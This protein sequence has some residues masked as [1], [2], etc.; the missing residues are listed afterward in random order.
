MGPMSEPSEPAPPPG[1][2]Q[3]TTTEGPA[4][5][6]GAPERPPG[7][8]R[9][10]GTPVAPGLALGNVH[11][12]HDELS[13]VTSERV[14]L[15]GIETELNR[16]HRALLDARAQLTWLKERLVGRV[17]EEEAR[18]LDVHVAY[19]KDS[20]F[21][22]DVENLILEEQLCLEAAIVKVIADFDRIF[23]LVQNETLRSRAVDLRDVGIRVLRQLERRQ[24]SDAE[25]AAEPTDYVLVARELSIVDMFNLEGDHVLGILTEEGGLT[26]HAAVLARSMRIP[27]LTGVR[28]LLTRVKEGDFVIVDATEG[29]A[30]LEPEAR[31]REQYQQARREAEQA[32]TAEAGVGWVMRPPLT[33]D[34]ERVQVAS[35]CGTLPEVEQAVRSGSAE[36][37]LYRTELLYLVDKTQPS[38][39]TLTRHY[40]AVLAQA[41]GR[42]VAIRLLHA[43]S[44][45]GLKYLHPVRELNPAL[46]LIGVRALLAHESV[47]RRQLQAILR[48]SVDAEVAILVPNVTDAGELRR[49]KEI[50]FEERLELKKTGVEHSQ[51]LELGAVLETPA[52]I[53]GVR[54]L[55]RECD[56]LV[57]ALDSTVQHLLG[58]DRENGAVSS[59][60]EAL[61][62]YVMR[63]VSQVVEAAAELE[64]PLAVFGFTSVQPHNLPFLLGLGVRRFIVPPV[65]LRE[66]LGELAQVDLAVAR[67]AARNARDS[68]CQDETLTLVDGYR[69]GYAR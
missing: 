63:A 5:A 16:F 54:D 32:D 6:A 20:V 28:E 49:I 2:V 47:L 18:I 7:G 34:G 3:E 12:K 31:V 50:L 10:R 42:P 35:S 56:R 1:D 44:S 14:P 59:W 61:H 27:T 4:E 17:P 11:C 60:F 25:A 58:A 9:L 23:K 67:R 48:A 40:Q 39:E 45:L 46:G 43:D 62:P 51:R 19:L 13:A 55:A 69:H 24:E 30:H 41:G 64:R 21:I 15:D 36:V 68:S 38:V 22:S 57:L 53:L 37:G 33:L 26:S 8:E 29:V 65:S 52:S 66:F